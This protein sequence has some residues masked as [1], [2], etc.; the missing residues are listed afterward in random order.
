MKYA[1]PFCLLALPAIADD[2]RQLAAHEHG[3]GE[4]NIAI[5]G[6]TLAMELHAPGADIV[7]FEYEATSAEDIAAIENAVSV[8]TK[9]LDLFVLP[10]A[11]GCA[12]TT[13]SA[14][15]EADFEDAHG[16]DEDHDETAEKHDHDDHG[17]EEHAEGEAEHTEFHAEYVMSCANPDAIS[18][19]EFA[20]FEKFENALEL[21]VQFVSDKGAQAFEVER[22]APVLDLNGLL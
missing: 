5:E 3:V 12:V 2:S 22:D 6:S 16:H 19:I 18:R 20:Y 7:G 15:L 11:A 9:P 8:L 21:E 10:G 13:A 1:L 4:L 14:G 17:D